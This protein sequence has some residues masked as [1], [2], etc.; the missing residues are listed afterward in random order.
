VAEGQRGVTVTLPERHLEPSLNGRPWFLS[1]PDG[2]WMFSFPIPAD[3]WSSNDRLTYMAVHTRKKVWREAVA[4]M[5]RFY[6]IP[7]HDRWVVQAALPFRRKSDRRDPHNWTG[8]AV[9]AVLDGFTDAGFWPDDNAKHV[10]VID[11][12][13]LIIPKP[14][15]LTMAIHAWPTG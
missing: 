9:K 13:Q 4:K 5:A 10:F 8:T 12:Y 6:S 3:M 7:A 15:Q 11:G 1:R 2:E 14:A